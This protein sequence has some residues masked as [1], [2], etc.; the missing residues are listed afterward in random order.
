MKKMTKKL[1]LSKETYRHLSSRNLEPVV[2][3]TSAEEQRLN[4]NDKSVYW[5]C[6]CTNSGMY[7]CQC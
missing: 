1:G 2:G 3:A 4:P 6:V 7:T 5:S